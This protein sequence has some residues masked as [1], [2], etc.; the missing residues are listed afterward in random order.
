MPSGREAIRGAVLKQRCSLL[1]IMPAQKVARLSISVGLATIQ[2][3]LCPG[4]SAEEC[5]TRFCRS[6]A[7]IPRVLG[8]FRS[9]DGGWRRA[10]ASRDIV[11]DGC[12]FGV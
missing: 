10:E 9:R 3:V 12:D 1:E 4:I 8:D 11:R 6:I 7:Y 5:R 2:F